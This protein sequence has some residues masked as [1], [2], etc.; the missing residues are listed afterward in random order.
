M[1]GMRMME[2]DPILQLFLNFGVFNVVQVNLF[3]QK[4]GKWFMLGGVE[5]RL[6]IT[7]KVVGRENGCLTDRFYH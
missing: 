1:S 7:D 5:R 3:F 6:T 2:V 4:R